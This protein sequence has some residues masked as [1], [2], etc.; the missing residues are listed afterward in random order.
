MGA[1]TV[2]KG[3]NVLP[4]VRMQVQILQTETCKG[5]VQAR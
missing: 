2:V 4:V 3:S 1:E 5:A